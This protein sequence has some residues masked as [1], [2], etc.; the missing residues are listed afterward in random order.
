MLLL[1]TEAS[2]KQRDKIHNVNLKELVG[3]GYD[4]FWK[5]RGR[6]RLVKGGRGSKKSSTIALWYIYHM[7]LFWY[8]FGIKVEMLCLR[9]Y[10]VNHSDSTYAQLKWAIERLGVSHL[11]RAYRNPLHIRFLPSGGRIIFRGLDSPDKITSIKSPDG[12]FAWIWV[13]EAYEVKSAQQFEKVNLS[14]RG[15]M[16]KPLFYQMTFSF[17]PYSEKTWLKSRYFDKVDEHTGLSPDGQIMAITRNYDCNEFLDEGFLREMERIKAEHPNEYNVVGLGNWGI[18]RGLV[19]SN[20]SVAEVRQA[21]RV[22]PL[23]TK[24]KI[25]A[26]SGFVLRCGLD[27]GFTNDITAFV[28]AAVNVRRKEI[29]VL[30]E[31]TGRG[32]TPKAIATAILDRGV[33]FHSTEIVADSSNPMAIDLIRREGVYGIVRSVKGQGS[34]LAGIDNLRQFK[35]FIDPTCVNVRTEL[36]NYKWRVSKEDEDMFL[37]EP[38]DEFNHCMDALRYA[39]EKARVDF[40]SKERR[41]G[42]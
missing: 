11:W 35:M 22:I 27:F 34:V 21:G 41:L 18:Q 33:L 24:I 23:E 12:H 14:L 10:F 17:N 8:K 38:I 6:Y 42:Y 39:M 2:K 37:N 32:M 7:M 30:D 31:T 13:E 26:Q 40:F 4:E 36:E 19:F 16:P 3:G 20:W 9:A 28:V 15:I 5:F 25:L 1:G 29:Y